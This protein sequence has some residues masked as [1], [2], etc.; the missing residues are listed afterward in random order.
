MGINEIDIAGLEIESKYDRNGRF[1]RAVYFDG[2][3][4]QYVKVWGEDFFYK[5]YFER[6]HGLHF[7]D[8]IAR[9]NDVLKNQDGGVLGY[10]TEAGAVV[11]EQNLDRPKLEDLTA[12][13]VAAT[14]RMR[15]VYVDYRLQNI[16]EIDGVYYIIDL[17]AC[18]EDSCL[19][20]IPGIKTTINH[21]L[22]DYRK[23]ISEFT[24][25]VDTLSV[26]KGRVGGEKEIKYGSANGR[27]WLEKE[28]LPKVGGRCL[29]IG[30]NY[31]T[32][33]YHRLV[34]DPGLFETLDVQENL[35][36]HG[37]PHVH[38]VCNLLDFDGLGYLYDNV[39]CF[40]LF[41]HIDSPWEITRSRG[42]IIGCLRVLDRNLKPGGRLLFGP[43][44]QALTD[45]F[46][47][48]VFRE[49]FGGSYRFDKIHKIDINII[50]EAT[51]NG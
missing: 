2:A 37:S 39:I 46:W 48:G 51:K 20:G 14:Y 16:V 30:V 42:E 38:H 18:I 34:K 27:V 25:G 50:L 4:H 44:T 12:R 29:F 1:N 22:Y 24:S 17:E 8:G 15:I 10:I 13:L 3:N 7:Y 23:R 43:A 11:D 36:C 41:G 6:A 45:N 9:V 21:C 35:I 28:Y 26:V 47:T 19:G 33:F 49:V 32:E 31:Y 40:G 5:P